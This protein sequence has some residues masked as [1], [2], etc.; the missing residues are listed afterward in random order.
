MDI[1]KFAILTE[2]V[3]QHVLGF[4]HL[5]CR[6]A[7]QRIPTCVLRVAILQPLIYGSVDFSMAKLV[8]QRRVFFQ[9]PS[10]RAQSVQSIIGKFELIAAKKVQ[11]NQEHRCRFWPW[12]Q[13]S[14][15]SFFDLQPQ[16]FED[17][18]PPICAGGQPL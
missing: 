2:A 4:F 5:C 16:P 17:I 12:F 18:V 15:L 1:I 9:L 13:H 7:Q 8:I 6:E 3:A 14:V 11:A 10:S